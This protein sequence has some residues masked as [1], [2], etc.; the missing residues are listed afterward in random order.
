M[1]LEVVATIKLTHVKGKKMYWQ[2]HI[3]DNK[4]YPQMPVSLV[5]IYCLDRLSL[6]TWIGSP[7]M[8]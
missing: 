7:I 3:L 5:V 4:D 6:F 1:L 8:E 2:H